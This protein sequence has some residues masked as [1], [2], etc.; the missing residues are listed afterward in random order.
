MGKFGDAFKTTLGVGAGLAVSN[1]LFGPQ[2]GPFGPFA[3]GPCFPFGNDL[4]NFD[5]GFGGREYAMGRMHQREIDRGREAYA[6]EA[7]RNYQRQ[8][9][10]NVLAYGGNYWGVAQL[11]RRY[12]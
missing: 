4:Y 5:R 7:G 9:D 1:A 12:V 2:F 10:R 3:M 11:D 6:F 8:L